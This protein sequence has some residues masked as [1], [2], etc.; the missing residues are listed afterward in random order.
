MRRRLLFFTI[1]EV[2]HRAESGY[3]RAAGQEHGIAR[4]FY[5][6]GGLFPGPEGD[7]E[8]YLLRMS[9][10]QLKDYENEIRAASSRLEQLKSGVGKPSKW[11]LVRKSLSTVLSDVQS[12][13][14]HKG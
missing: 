8:R 4:L 14:E 10:A 9:K 13:A 5:I 3:F 6:D 12:I 7:R 1:V 2:F 11:E